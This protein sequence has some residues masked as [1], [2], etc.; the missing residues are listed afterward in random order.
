MEKEEITEE[1]RQRAEAN[2]AT[3]LA[4]RKA[5]LSVTEK[6]TLQN[7]NPW[8]LF[9]CQKLSPE[10]TASFSVTKKPAIADSSVTSQTPEKFRARLE[11]CSPDSFSITS[12]PVDGFVFP[13]ED[14]CF[15]RLSNCLSNAVLSHYTQNTGGGKSC[16][17]RI[18]DYHLI[19]RSLKNCKGIECEEI[20]WGTL[21]VIER[22]SHSFI[23][24]KW[25]PC[26]P[27]HLP[28]EKVDK[29]IAELPKTLLNAL[30]PF[31]V[32]G[33]RFG[34]RRGGRCLIADEM[35]LG[36]TLQAIA[37]AG[38]F[39]KEGS[40]LVVCPAIL[41]YSW[42]EELER[43]F[44][45]CLP[46]DVHLVFGHQDNPARLAKLPRVVVISYTML[47]RLQSSM[48]EKEWVTLIVDESHHL[49]CNKKSNEK[50]ELKVLL[51]VA[52]KVKHLILLSGTPSLSRPGLLGL[53][54]FEFAKTY[55]SVKFARGCQGKVYQD[56]SK[57][58]R[59]E[60]LNVLL[61]QSV[62]IRRL[63]EHVL[64]QLP[65]KRRQIIKLILRK[66]D[67]N[68]A[69]ATLG[70]ETVDT[71]ADT[72]AENAPIH[73][74]DEDQ[75]CDMNK[76]LSKK[77][78]ALG[79][80]K[81][82]GFFE[83][84]SIHPIMVEVDGEETTEESSS[85]HKMIV[86][87]YHHKV[88]DG[89]QAFLCEKGIQFV[90]IDCTITGND[91]QL[92]IQSFQSSKKVKIALIG[93]RAG[94]SGLN[95]TSADNVVF[96]ELPMRPG[97]IQQAEDRAHRHGQKRLVNV[98][99]FC[100]KDTS[101][102]LQWQQLNKSLLRVSST[103]NG[104]HDAIQELEVERVSYLESTTNTSEKGKQLTR[105]NNSCLNLESQLP[106][107][108][109]DTR[110][111]VNEGGGE[112]GSEIPLNEDGCVNENEF[113]MKSSV[114]STNLRFAVS[115]HTGRIHLYSCIPGTNSRPRPLFKNF[116]QE[117]VECRPL[118]EKNEETSDKSIEDDKLYMG[119][120]MAFI[121]EWKE[122]RPIEKRK[123][124]NKPLQ[125]PLSYE[126]CYLN[127]SLNH[128][129]EG[130]LRGGSKRRK[131]PMAEISYTLPSNASWRKV[132]L[133]SGHGQKEKLYTQGWTD[134]DE[135]LC[136]L[137][138][139]PCKGNNAKAPQ[140]FE[141]LFCGLDCFEEYRSRTSNRFLREELFKIEHGIC[142]NCKLNCPQLV[143][144]L[145]V[146]P[147]EKRQAHIRNKAPKIAKRNKL[148]DK[149]VHD[150]T[151]GNAW[152]ADHIIPVY[153][154][155]GECKL[156]NLRTLCVV[157][158]ADVTTAQCSERRIA[159]NKAK[160]Q[161]KEAMCGLI[162]AE[163]SGKND[164]VLQDHDLLIEIPGSAYS[165]TCV[166]KT[167][168]QNQEQVLLHGCSEVPGDVHSQKS[169]QEPETP[170]DSAHLA[171][172]MTGER[173]TEERENLTNSAQPMSP[174]ER[175]I[176]GDY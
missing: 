1:Q 69:M 70:L 135:P 29:L 156:E 41:R 108:S 88:L 143:K 158:H 78:S 53:T 57:G 166:Y 116:R 43:W 66:S 174:Q 83:W 131:T 64:L 75:D 33:L 167:V 68:S 148:L 118:A 169:C 124:L 8:K 154:G 51:E 125:L 20:P 133:Y 145:K 94:S 61:K 19:L 121:K 56:F 126:L 170:R 109:C 35:G 62:M 22:L 144:D 48:L 59:L 152:H 24:G 76:K 147:I 102:E 54:K 172:N 93:I 95:L 168:D 25:I 146:L 105:F 161:L 165:V 46:S 7:N 36:K 114:Q 28:D 42:A 12:V 117:E 164:N 137:C 120:L 17:Y 132:N 14:V 122:L 97:D 26:R 3:A 142:T 159:R 175:L 50:D 150:P 136:K 149:L 67:I 73:V 140:Y 15:E 138:Q 74:A 130:L 38:C 49:H 104:K 171:Q 21:N 6:T 129:N 91:R 47:R 77:L 173:D 9:K 23:A 60:E 39:M 31:Q 160:K 18:Y 58:I 162:N 82:P 34:V 52:A 115:Q 103:V 100:A 89:V 16:V 151:E 40:I 86:F 90:R 110:V 55:C 5:I 106:R 112:R 98:Y 163:K 81:L 13:G 107:A 153:K 139:T 79:L 96:L 127:E 85:S 113:G 71:S 101:D 176:P 2:R 157:C 4:K 141:D 44:P 134:M 87:A 10:A 37:I 65:P 155:G 11:I 32:D 119:A 128:D 99:I 111:K 45:F 123:L 80:A 84:L 63:K 92:A 72:N 27:E 30:L